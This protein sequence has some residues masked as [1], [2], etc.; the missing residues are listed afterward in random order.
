M[1]YEIILLG[2]IILASGCIDNGQTETIEP[3]SADQTST[4]TSL[5]NSSEDNTVYLTESGFQP[6]EITVEQGET[7]TWI[8][9]A[10]NVMWVASDQHP[11]H[12]NY[13]DSSIYEH[14]QSGDQTESAFDQC[15]TGD[16]FSFTFEKTGEWSYHNHERAVQGGTVTVE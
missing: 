3:D 14:C 16:E 8:N 10:S 5:A 15:S 4:P 7:V 13:A 2:L 1:K 11:S 6:S 12:T 9:N